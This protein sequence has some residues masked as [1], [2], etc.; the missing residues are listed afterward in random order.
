MPAYN[1]VPPTLEGIQ[2]GRHVDRP[3]S[4]GWLTGYADQPAA[5]WTASH[6]TLPDCEW[7]NTG[8][9]F[10]SNLY[11]PIFALDGSWSLLNGPI[12]VKPWYWMD[13]P[14]LSNARHSL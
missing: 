3:R 4:D 6:D 14:L 7:S 10:S 12:P 5:H 2:R 1:S 13:L 11:T 8:L 9:L